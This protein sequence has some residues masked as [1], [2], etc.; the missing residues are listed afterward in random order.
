MLFFK[1]ILDVRQTPAT[2]AERRDA[3]RFPVNREFPLQA[4]LNIA[5]RDGQGT[6]LKPQDRAGWDWPGRL[7]DLSSTGARLQVPVTVAVQ[8]HDAGVLKLDVQGYQL[9]IPCVVANV[10]EQHEVCVFGLALD[11]EATGTLEGYRQL[12]DLVALGSTLRLVQPAQPDPSGYLLEQYAGEPASRLSIWRHHEGREVS[13]FEFQLKD[14]LVRGL[15]DRAE[16]ECF[17][18]TEAGLGRVVTQTHWEEIYRLY[19]WVVL[20]LAAVV[21]ADA[22]AFLLKHAQ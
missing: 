9:D 8:R 21:P 17:A 11:L 3:T 20:N 18:T 2:P 4:V 5:G 6:L 1:R 16:L 14:S 13:A 12:L 7:L 15:A 10:A 22:R 19:Q